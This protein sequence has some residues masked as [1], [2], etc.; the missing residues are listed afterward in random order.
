MGKGYIGCFAFGGVNDVS[1]RKGCS[2]DAVSTGCGDRPL[3]CIYL[4]CGQAFLGSTLSLN[5]DMFSIFRAFHRGN[6]RLGPILSCRFCRGTCSH[7]DLALACDFRGGCGTHG[8]RVR[9]SGSVVGQLWG[10]K[11]LFLRIPPFSSL[12]VPY[13]SAFRFLLRIPRV[14]FCQGS[15]IL[16]LIVL[17]SICPIT[18]NVR[19]ST[20]NVTR[21]V[22][23]LRSTRSSTKR[24]ITNTQRLGK[25]FFMKRRR[26]LFYGVV[27]ACRNVLALCSTQNSRRKIKASNSRFVCRFVNF[28]LESSLFLVFQVHRRAD[29]NVI[30]GAR[31]QC[32]RRLLRTSRN[33]LANSAVRLTMVTRR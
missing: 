31:V 15:T 3:N 17:I 18:R 28:L 2:A 24:S 22:T 8:N 10:V 19:N 29:L 33:A 9:G 6:C 20:N 32:T 7:C 26:V 4:K 11:G 16:I 30:K 13:F 14:P 1:I 23:V 27:R 25:S 21:V 12:S 5:F